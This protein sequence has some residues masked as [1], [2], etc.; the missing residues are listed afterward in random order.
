MGF[1]FFWKHFETIHWQ[2]WNE[3]IEWK[4]EDLKGKRWPTKKSSN[5][6]QST[7]YFFFGYDVPYPNNDPHQKEFEE[8][9]TLFIVKELVILFLCWSSIF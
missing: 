9:L 4:K 8:D 6:T 3:N 1:L 5:P 7:I 2:L